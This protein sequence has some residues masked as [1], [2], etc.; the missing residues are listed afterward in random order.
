[1]RRTVDVAGVSVSGTIGLLGTPRGRIVLGG[2]V[3][4]TLRLA[5]YTLSGRLD[6]ARVRARVTPP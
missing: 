3:H 2:R 1:M 5:G 4:G 6:G